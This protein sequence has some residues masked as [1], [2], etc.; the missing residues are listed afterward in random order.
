MPSKSTNKAKRND[1]TGY[2]VLVA[3]IAV[4]AVA[5]FYVYKAQQLS[6]LPPEQSQTAALLKQ[7]KPPLPTPTPKHIPHGPI[8]FQ[9]STNSLG[10]KLGYG[11]LNPRDPTPTNPMIITVKVTDT[12][13]VQ[14]VWATMKTDNK[15]T[16]RIIFHR[17][18]GTD[19][20]GNWQGTWTPNDT[21][22]YTYFLTF[23]ATSTNGDTKV[24]IELL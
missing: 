20:S 5:I 1:L 4:I 3:V 18:D 12:V 11:T 8:D 10:P 14:A 22:H 13:P 6:V 15:T 2:L 19:M 21:Y 24:E 16:P 17:V 7:G 23:G 9:I